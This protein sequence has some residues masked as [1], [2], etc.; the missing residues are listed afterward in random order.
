MYPGLLSLSSCLSMSGPLQIWYTIGANDTITSN[1]TAGWTDFYVVPLTVSTYNCLVLSWP[2]YSTPQAM[3]PT[4]VMMIVTVQ[5][6]VLAGN[7]DNL[8]SS[9]SSFHFAQNPCDTKFGL[10]I[11]KDGSTMSASREFP[12]TKPVDLLAVEKVGARRASGSSERKSS[13]STVE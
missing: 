13:T 1:T 3:Y 2:T 6:S 8:P 11:I 4:L 12:G 9:A 5:D 7:A 10:A